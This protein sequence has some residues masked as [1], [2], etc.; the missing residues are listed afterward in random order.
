MQ[1]EKRSRFLELYFHIVL[2]LFALVSIGISILN[3]GDIQGLKSEIL[4][5]ASITTLC[6]SL[7]IFG[8]KFG[9]TAANHRACYLALQKLRAERKGTASE[10]ETAYIEILGHHPN[11]TSGDFKRLIVNNVLQRKQVLESP[12]GRTVELDRW[13]RVAF[14]SAWLLVRIALIV[15]ALMPFVMAIYGTFPEVSF[16]PA[17]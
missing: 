12:P 7:L 16:A 13:D 3:G 11:H 1:A 2:A 5:F 15:F 8:F 10:L 14:A 17:P 9:E 4:T 6:L